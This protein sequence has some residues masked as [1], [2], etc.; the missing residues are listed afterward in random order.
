MHH[1]ALNG[2]GTHDGHFDHEIVKVPR[3]EARQHGHLGSR[4]DLKHADGVGAANHFVHG[5]I[6]TRYA[7]QLEFPGTGG[8]GRA[9]EFID[10]AKGAPYRSQH[11]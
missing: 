10:Q 11:A 3:P 8:G 7:G 9:A 5:L 6:F 4:F 1:L 2:A